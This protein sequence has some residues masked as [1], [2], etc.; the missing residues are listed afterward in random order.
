MYVLDNT[1]TTGPETDR[2][3]F[4]LAKQCHPWLA[5]LP[6]DR[7]GR[8]ECSRIVWNNSCRVAD[9]LNL[10][11]SISSPGIVVYFEIVIE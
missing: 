8:W 3:K 10:S 6:R 11:L 1:D 7:H 5:R 2:D 4:R 9:G